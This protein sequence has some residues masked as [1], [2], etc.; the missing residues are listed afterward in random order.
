MDGTLPMP[1]DSRTITMSG[2]TNIIS[3]QGYAG[4]SVLTDIKFEK[5]GRDPKDDIYYTYTTDRKKKQAQ[6]M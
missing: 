5:G 2:T 1:N 4:K 6:L 3:Y